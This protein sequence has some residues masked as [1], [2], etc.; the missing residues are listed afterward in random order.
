M[1]RLPLNLL[2]PFFCTKLCLPVHL[3][4][5]SAHLFRAYRIGLARLGPQGTGLGQKNE[6]A[7]LDG[8]VRFFNRV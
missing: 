2:S 6:L 4:Y 5:F 7:S 3:T 8:T 1:I